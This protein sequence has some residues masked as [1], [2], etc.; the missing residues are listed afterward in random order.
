MNLFQLIAAPVA[1][2]LCVRSALGFVRGKHPR[3]SSLAAGVIWFLSALFIL[4]PDLTMR[5]ARVLGIGRGADLVLYLFAILFIT[6]FFYFYARFRFIESQLTEIVRHLSFS[7]S[8]LPNKG[9]QSDSSRS[10][11]DSA[12]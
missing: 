3:G 10:P 7:T 9:A 8:D 4:R 1:T 12:G 2:I 6:S 5:V 11:E